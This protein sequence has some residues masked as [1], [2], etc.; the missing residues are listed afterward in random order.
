MQLRTRCFQA[1]VRRWAGQ[2]LGVDVRKALLLEVLT[3]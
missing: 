2:G 1:G 3:P